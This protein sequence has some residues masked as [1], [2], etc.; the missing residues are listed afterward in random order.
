MISPSARWA[1]SFEVLIIIVYL[2]VR[3][4]YNMIKFI[5]ILFT[6]FF[7]S[8]ASVA[9]AQMLE[10][11]GDV[12]SSIGDV[13]AK[14]ENGLRT[15]K[16]G[17]DIY[18]GDTI[19]TADGAVLSIILGDG[20]RVHFKPSSTL[21]VESINI[22]DMG[23]VITDVHIKRGGISIHNPIDTMLNKFRVSTPVG[24]ILPDGGK[25]Y[26]IQSGK[27]SFD[28]KL[29]SGEMDVISNIGEEVKLERPN[30]KINVTLNEKLPAVQSMSDAEIRQLEVEF[31]NMQKG[32]MRIQFI[33]LSIFFAYL[34][35]IVVYYRFFKK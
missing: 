8:F 23:N 34:V 11:V 2:I 13:V 3:S 15:L 19:I 9:S 32:P 17:G 21:I 18:A 30:T 10:D 26:A 27:D 1:F 25:V 35:G 14:N 7:A 6:L 12:L 29:I 5:R 24:E 33:I 28:F 22:D 4:G 20:R 16:A 31:E